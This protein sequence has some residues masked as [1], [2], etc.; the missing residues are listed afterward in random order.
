M[1]KLTTLFLAV[2]VTG[3]LL[4]AQS[5]DEARIS[6]NNGRI[7]T[8][9]QTLGKVL[10]A[11]NK[12]AE[13]IYWLGQAYLATDDIA[14]AKKVYQDALNGG[15]TD[16]LIVV[17]MGHIALLEGNKADAR[18]RFDVAISTSMN[19]KKENPAILNA[20]GRANADGGATIGDPAYAIEKLKKAAEL[21]PTNADIFINLGIN[22]IKI[23]DGTNAYEAYTNA[24]RVDP[25]NAK[26]NFRLGK[27]FQSQ[28][29]KEKFLEYYNNAITANSGFTPAYLELYDYYS[30]RDVNKAGD[31]LQKY[32]A[33]SDQ[34]CNTEFL[35]AD[36][37][38]RSGKYQESLD[39]TRAMENGSCK[40]FPRLKVLYAYIYDRKAN[41]FQSIN[42]GAIKIGSSKQEVLN[43]FGSSTRT[44]KTT[45]AMG[46][47]ELLFFKDAEVNIDANGLVSYIHSVS[48]AESSFEKYQEIS[49]QAKSYMDAYM[50][51]SD[52]NKIQSTD[53]LIAASISRKVIGGEEAAIGYLKKALDF[54][55]VRANRKQYID[56]IAM[57]YKKSGKMADRLEWLKRSYAL[58]P[59]PNNVDIYN[60]ADAAIVTGNY[61]LADTMANAYIQKYPEQDYGYT[62][63]IRGA[64]AADS[65]VVGAFPAMQQYIDFMIK[66]DATANAAKIVSQYTTMASVAADKL[67]DYGMALD[68]VNKILAIEPANSFATSAKPLLEK[69]LKGGGSTPKKA[70]SPAKKGK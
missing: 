61:A 53:Y 58:N 38:F 21:D 69:A 41:E 2:L 65:T 39:K 24:L 66:K 22:Y 30:N 57:L 47:E 67:K 70:T 8:A 37:L 59:N 54:D 29:N 3:Q 46:T 44:S 56:T 5:V 51:T 26:A 13:A 64:K 4:F 20:I 18:Q 45:T 33:N 55:T 12:N 17:G 32:V 23:N 49:K 31:Y 48:G 62:L 10:L 42:I 1:K 60:M 68:L 40:S 52:P 28:G 6:L 50:T 19:K 14:G 34:D 25:K 35:Y 63:K 43:A 9:K 15:V 27:L 7:A 36:Y 16:A 11:N